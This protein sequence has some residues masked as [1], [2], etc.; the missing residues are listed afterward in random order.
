MIYLETDTEFELEFN[1]CPLPQYEEAFVD[2]FY[3]VQYTFNGYTETVVGPDDPML[4]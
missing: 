2:N 4:L 1:F 3:H